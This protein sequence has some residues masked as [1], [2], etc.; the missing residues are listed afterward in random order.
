MNSIKF[1]ASFL[2][3]HWTYQTLNECINA[4]VVILPILKYK[5][6]Q[7]QALIFSAQTLLMLSSRNFLSPQENGMT[8]KLSMGVIQ[9]NSKLPL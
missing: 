1:K 2:A 9:S 3:K 5:L 7:N 6:K 8:V 4:S